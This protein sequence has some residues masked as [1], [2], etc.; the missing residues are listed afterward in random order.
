MQVI[1]YILLTVN[2]CLSNPPE[3]PP[4]RLP[5]ALEDND[6]NLLETMLKEGK[7]EISRSSSAAERRVYRLFHSGKHTYKKICKI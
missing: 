1:I 6:Y 4:G 7:I 2:Y 3:N 5:R